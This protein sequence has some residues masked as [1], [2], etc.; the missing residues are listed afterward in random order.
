MLGSRVR[1][2][3]VIY[4]PLLFRQ[5]DD[6]GE[7][8]QGRPGKGKRH[9]ESALREDIV[10]WNPG[11]HVGRGTQWGGTKRKASGRGAGGRA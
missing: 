6:V 9:R 3:F 1:H 4:H 5:E 2:R 11:W 10:M 7:R 8:E